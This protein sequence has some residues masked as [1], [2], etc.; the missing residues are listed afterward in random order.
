MT[1]ALYI[2]LF[3]ISLAVLLKASDWFVDSAEQIGLSLGISPFIIGVTIVAFG[4]SLPEL[5]TSIASVFSGESEIVVGNVVG[6]NI[7]NIALVLGLTAAFS[8]KIEL[9]YNIWHIDMPY[10]WGSAFLL[11]FALKD[12]HF[13]LIEAI[14]FLM[15]IVL[16]LAY[17]FKSD[18]GE[19]GGEKIE[20]SKVNW[21]TYLKLIGGGLFVWLGAD[22]TITAISELSAIAGVKPEIIALSAVALGTSLPEVIVSLNA[23]RKGKASMAVG[24]VLGS[25][26]FNTYIV[27][28]IPSFFGELKIPANINEMFLPLMIAMTILFGIMSNNKKIT[29]WEGILLLIFYAFFTAEL[30]KSAI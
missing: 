18:E 23:A 25:N 11:F 17:S 19:E 5:A 4:T 12:F 9:E 29:R 6:S 8:K 20:G 15:G 28:S 1:I 22:Y 10:L 13:S 24:N 2:G 3:V 16:F 30:F 21:K 14:L 7:T 26:I 27:M